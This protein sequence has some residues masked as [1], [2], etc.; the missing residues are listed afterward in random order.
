MLSLP[1]FLYSLG[2]LV[3]TVDLIHRNPG[4]TDAIGIKNT[5][6]RVLGGLDRLAR[7]SESFPSLASNEYHCPWRLI[8]LRSGAG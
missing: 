2:K 4:L 3:C 5:W 1:A 7:I 6:I 8:E